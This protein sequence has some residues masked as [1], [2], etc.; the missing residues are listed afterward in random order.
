MTDLVDLLEN[1][2][3]YRTT[4]LNHPSRASCPAIALR[5]PRSRPRG[6]PSRSAF[7]CSSGTGSTIRSW[8]STQARA[9][10][11]AVEDAGGTVESHLYRHELHELTD[12]ANRIEFHEKLA[13]F[14]AR[15]LSAIESL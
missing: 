9:M 15:H 10:V 5:S 14:F 8:T 2:E 3:H 7:P 6:S 4:D 11:D 13:A 12:E 1:P